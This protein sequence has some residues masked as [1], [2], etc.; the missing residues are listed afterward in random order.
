M[1]FYKLY[2][3]LFYVIGSLSA[4]FVILT[5]I[6]KYLGEER[7]ADNVSASGLIVIVTGLFIYVVTEIFEAI[8]KRIKRNH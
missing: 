1:N 5:L 4:F 8:V 2:L 6:F 3:R 7:I